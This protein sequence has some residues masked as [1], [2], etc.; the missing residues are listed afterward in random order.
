MVQIIYRGPLIVKVYVAMA[1]YKRMIRWADS[2]TMHG[3]SHLK[4][5]AHTCLAKM[6]WLVRMAQWNTLHFASFNYNKKIVV[7]QGDLR[8]VIIYNCFDFIAVFQTNSHTD[9]YGI[10]IVIRI[11]VMVTFTALM[12]YAV[13]ST[14]EGRSLN[15]EWQVNNCIN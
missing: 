4:N 6:F 11:L 8:E 7:F 9:G 14:L 5:E 2:T 3:W 13:A 15:G 1:M 12:T 10:I